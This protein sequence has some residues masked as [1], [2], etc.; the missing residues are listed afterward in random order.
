MVE[1]AKTMVTNFDGHI[2]CV[3]VFV[4]GVK[5]GLSSEFRPSNWGQQS[6]GVGPGW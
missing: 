6:T 3:R 1:I 2:V 5:H 4:N